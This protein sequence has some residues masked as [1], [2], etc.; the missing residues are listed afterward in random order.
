MIGKRLLLAVT[1]A[2][3]LVASSPAGSAQ[4]VINE[5]HYESAIDCEDSEFIELYNA[6]GGAVDL[7]GWRFASG[8]SYVFPQGTSIAAGGYLLVGQNPAVMQSRFNVAA[9]GP[10]DGSLS[11][12]GEKIEL[13]DAGGTE[14]DQVD[15][16]PRF[17]WPIAA[18]G[19]GQSMELV[20]PS[21]DN[22]LGS[23]WRSSQPP[24]TFGELPYIGEADAAWRYRPGRSEA[25]SPAGAW[26]SAGFAEDASWTTARTKI[27]FGA[28]STATFNTTLNDM[29][30]NYS[31]IFLRRTFTIAEGDPIPN[32]LILRHF[33][34]EGAVFWIN[35]VEVLRVAVAPGEPAFNGVSTGSGDPVA[36]TEARLTGTAG[37]LKTGNNVLAVQAFN[38][39]IGGSDFG[40]DAQLI[41]PAL[42][43]PPAVP[44]PGKHNSTFKTNPAPNIRQVAHT[45]ELPTSVQP[46]TITA[47]VTDP[48]GVASVELRYQISPPGNYIPA[49]LAH[50]IATLTSG[51]F[52][53]DTPRAPNPAFENPANWTPV[54]MVHTGDDIY[55]ATIPVQTNRALVRYRIVVTD[56]PGASDRAPFADDPSLNF[57]Y[58]VYDGVPDYRATTSVKGGAQVYPAAMLT[59]LPV[60]SLI[61]RNQDIVTAR[62][63]DGGD[64]LAHTSEARR[65]YNWEGAMVYDGVVYDHIN[66]RLRGANGRYQGAG[67][68]SW[69]FRFNRGNYL[70]ARDQ[71]GVP[72]KRP[73]RV[74]ETSKMFSNRQVGNFGMVDTI[75]GHL[76]RLVGVPAPHTFWFHF[77]VVDGAQEAPDQYSGDFWGM[78][79]G[80][81]RYD[82]LFLEQHG[83]EK[84]NLYKLVDG[85][86]SIAD[87]ERYQ[88]CHALTPRN[89]QDFN[90]AKSMNS[91]KP[92]QWI[93][94]NTNLEKWYHWSAVKQALRHYD[95][96][97]P[98]DKNMAWYFEPD[99]TAANNNNGRLWLLPYD[100][101]D[102]WG[103][104]WHDGVETISGSVANKPEILKEEKNVVRSFRNLL[105]QK[106]QL[107]SLIDSLASVIADFS[108]ADR[109]RWTN[110]PAQEGNE[111]WGSLEAKVAD[112]KRFAFEGGAWEIGPGGRAAFLDSY[113]SDAAIPATPTI[114]YSGSPGFPSTGL[115]F[116]SSA[117]AD[118]Q[119]GSGTFGG[120]EWRMAEVTPV[121][122]GTVT[123]FAAGQDWKYLDNGSDQGS[124]W[125][126]PGFDDSAWASGSAPLG[127]GGITNTV[128]ATTINS[129][130][131]VSNRYITTY[132]RRK[133]NI[134][135]P[136]ALSTVIFKMHVDDGAVVYVNGV[137]VLRD[138]IS[139]DPV[140][141]Y[142]TLAAG[143][144][145]EGVFDAFEV[146]AAYFVAGENTIAVELHQEG[147]GSSDLVFD[148]ALDAKQRLLPVGESLK[149][150]WEADWES[151]V[152]TTFSNSIA[153]PASVARPAKT[154][155]ARVRHRDNTGR[156]SHWSTPVEFVAIAPNPV[157]LQK[158]LVVSEFM[159]HPAAATLAEAAAGFA[160]GD[161][162]YIEIMNIGNEALDLS[163]VRFTKGV[164]FDFAGS[165]ITSIA[166]GARVLVVARRAAFESR[167]GGGLPVA[168][169]WQAGDRLSNGGENLKLSVG[170]GIPIREF[171]YLDEAPWPSAADGLGFSVVLINPQ[172]NP[173]HTVGTNWRASVAAGG[174][175]G[176]GDSTSLAAWMVANGVTLAGLQSDNDG[177]GLSG[178][179]EYAQGTPPHLASPD[180]GL[181]SI[182][183][184]EVSGGGI[185]VLLTYLKNTAADDVQVSI[186]RSW[187][188]GAASAWQ[189]VSGEFELAADAPA[190][191]GRQ[192]LTWRSAQPITGKPHACW[193]VRFAAAP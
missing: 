148:M 99:Y 152:L 103:P 39:S 94:D 59:R 27:G 40:F 97:S 92:E 184:E 47:K 130:G 116:R 48:D 190:P 123:V 50:P 60:Y 165:A 30:G 100:H 35:G 163:D 149:L 32:S 38:S 107:N 124:A 75:N 138:K 82:G 2:F 45:P 4:V 13:E 193:R 86:D 128:L 106:D 146:N 160:A 16:K 126:A 98:S 65:T 142:R 18:G 43:A 78:M 6:G 29:Q 49:F 12:E 161:F 176:G 52:N 34:D 57:A 95:W 5:I 15:Y 71:D 28:V 131:D 109:D 166:P 140:V 33:L 185:R 46:A 171:D 174:S 70:I 22:D 20:N 26:R 164:D 114:S 110:A 67:K 9:L 132:F 118:P 96:P 68:R 157:P 76:W 147:A 136:A 108:F 42:P 25:S 167:H 62:A 144:G 177:D 88:A 23:S 79:L 17:P 53:R 134:A 36:F 44:T 135:D 162:E 24:A 121:G 156:W 122:G 19:D 74:L 102:T 159:Y 21:L 172:A 61:T 189:D 56:T 14:I 125:R 112:M 80:Q 180:P 154:Y 111:N 175:P 83:L 91:S 31:C 54:A 150:E 168:G 186:E 133:V 141:H 58:F 137:E 178:L 127:Y 89:G 66:Y 191:G 179:R 169:E 64:Q 8:V 151:G 188:L 139:P 153:I 3:A 81:E 104:Y 143:G 55:S 11:N 181:V 10:W 93:R 145:N 37:Y 7:S 182:A 170:A 187:D 113:S 115:A 119:G 158:T 69:K 90:N 101:D 192:A 51:G 117:F 120:M 183:A 173:D 105:W 84:G 1:C 72:F 85:I 155:R 41:R 87:E 77:R 73:W 63:Y 129:G